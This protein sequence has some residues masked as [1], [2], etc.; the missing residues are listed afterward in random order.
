MYLFF[1]YK[2][3]KIFKIWSFYFKGKSKKFYEIYYVIRKDI[4]NDDHR[5]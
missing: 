3:S 2:Y 4:V 1:K 5:K